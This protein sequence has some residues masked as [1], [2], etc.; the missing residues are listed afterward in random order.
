VP[1]YFGETTTARDHLLTL[2]LQADSTGRQAITAAA[3]RIEQILT[4]A[5]DSVGV[6]H[7][8]GQLP[9]ARRIDVPPLAAVFVYLASVGQVSVIDYL[10]AS[11]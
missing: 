8:F 7:P 10:D 6:P 1:F 9:T 4:H 2:W 11:P 3:H 5:G